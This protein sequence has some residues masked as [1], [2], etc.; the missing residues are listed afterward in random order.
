MN[1]TPINSNTHQRHADGL[2]AAMDGKV[3]VGQGYNAVPPVRTPEVERI[4]ELEEE[5][6]AL[7]AR[8]AEIEP[9]W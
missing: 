8:L 1:I 2:V 4:I 3:A 6:I 5:V 7:R 9:E